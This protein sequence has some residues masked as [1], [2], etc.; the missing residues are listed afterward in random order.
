MLIQVLKS[1]LK[2]VIVTAADTKY[3]GSITLD[4]DLMDAAQLW[5]YERVEIN[6]VNG[7][8]RITTY[9]ISGERGSGCVELNGG[10]ANFFVKGQHIHVNC[11]ASVK[12]PP[13]LFTD[14]TEDPKSYHHGFYGQYYPKI[15]ITD[16][17]NKVI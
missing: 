14:E 17:N 4:P 11:F 7:E 16:E 8:S 15:V 10:A 2:D 3:E 1:K 9:V 6:A 5:P 13:H 12:L